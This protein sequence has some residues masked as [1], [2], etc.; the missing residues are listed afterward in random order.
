MV[1]KATG[2]TRLCADF[3]ELNANLVN[4]KYPLPHIDDLLAEIGPQTKWFS[5]FDLEAA[6]HQIPLE[7]DSQP[8]TTIVTQ[9]GTYKYKV[10]SFG[11]KTAPAVFQRIIEKVVKN[12]ECT[13]AYLEDI[14]VVANTR[15]EFVE[16]TRRVRHQ[17][18]DV[19]LK[20]NPSKSIETV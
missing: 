16:R 8:L 15:E 20:L 3:R 5:G 7:E 4:D 19:G 14:L 6:Y 10:M 17:I 1:R 2:A 18:E 9:F 13:M 12:F 11:I